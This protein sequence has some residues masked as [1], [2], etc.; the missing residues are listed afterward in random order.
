MD[1]YKGMFV[2]CTI[3]GLCAWHQAIAGPF[4]KNLNAKL[5]CDFGICVLFFMHIFVGLRVKV[6]YSPQYYLNTSVCFDQLS[7]RNNLKGVCVRACVCTKH[8]CQ[9]SSYQAL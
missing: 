4:N 5:I 9:V 7:S 3:N 8:T 2:L 1:A 6:S